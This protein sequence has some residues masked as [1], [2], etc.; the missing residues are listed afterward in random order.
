LGSV[1]IDAAVFSRSL[2]V[3]DVDEAPRDGV[4]D[5]TIGE[6]A[7]VNTGD[8]GAGTGAL[9]LGAGDRFP[10]LGEPD[11]GLLGARG[12][13]L[14]SLSLSLSSSSLSSLLLCSSPEL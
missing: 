13:S 2:V 5:I 11:C 4:G 3:L 7:I 1:G 8:S 6:V 12:T 10:G 14:L 9:K